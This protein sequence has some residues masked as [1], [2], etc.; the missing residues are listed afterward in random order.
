L[1]ELVTEHQKNKQNQTDRPARRVR[2]G[3]LIMASTAQQ[4]QVDVI[5]QGLKNKNA[6]VRIQAAQELQR[7]ARF[8][9]GVS[10][11]IFN[12]FF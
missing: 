12:A 11:P 5:F 1:I 2:H 4:S 6:D 3:C 9:P 10:E 8:S 7:Y